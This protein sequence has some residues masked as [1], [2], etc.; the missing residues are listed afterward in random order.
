MDL[1]GALRTRDG[2]LCDICTELMDFSLSYQDPM[3]VTIEHR[4]RRADGGTNHLGNLALA[5]KRC[6]NEKGGQDEVAKRAAALASGEVAIRK[7]IARHKRKRPVPILQDPAA[8][9]GTAS[10]YESFSASRSF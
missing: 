1:R 6:N 8:V 9:L 10:W 4:I 2:D 3:G 5:H 7:S